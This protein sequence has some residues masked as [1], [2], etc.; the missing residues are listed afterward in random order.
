MILYDDSK[1]TLAYQIWDQP[2]KLK[3][4]IDALTHSMFLREVVLPQQIPQTIL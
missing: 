1:N 3:D 4:D 2:F